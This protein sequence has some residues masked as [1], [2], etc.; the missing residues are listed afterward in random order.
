MDFPNWLTRLCEKIR[1][2]GGRAL[3]VGGAVRDRF[4]GLPSKDFDLEVYG[5]DGLELRRL[6]ESLG[7]VNAV[8]EQFVVYK[9][10]PTEAPEDEADVSLP[11]RESKSG[12]GHRGFVI[13]GDP[14]MS[15]FEATR[16]RDFTIN[17]LMLDP[18]SG[19]VIDPQDGMAD[20][21][22]RRLRVVDPKTFIEDSLRVLRGAQFAARFEFSLAPETVAL[23]RTIPLDDLPSERVWG[24]FEKLLTKAVRP[25]IGFEALETLSA[26]DTCFPEL[27]ELKRKSEPGGAPGGWEAML[28]GIDEGARRIGDLPREKKVTVMLALTARAFSDPSGQSRTESFLDRL[29]VFSL[30]GYDV[31][32]QVIAL[33]AEGGQPEKLIENGKPAPDGAF[34]RLALRVDGDLLYRVA[35]ASAFSE[36][37][38]IRVEKFR[39]RFLE[40]G[41]DL[42]PPKPVLLGRHLLEMGVPPGPGIGNLTRLVFERQLEGEVTTL[43][44]A[45]AVALGIL[46]EPG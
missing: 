36:D 24:E 14:A 17:A 42:G 45:R 20:V 12:R 33:V 41:L 9:F 15:F 16:R 35:S 5:V 26:L 4:L 18:L 44:E 8:G 28:A 6:L 32:K 46:S 21:K 19:E 39:K 34:R 38:K 11:R 13:E 25:S 43:D 37:S 23:C 10:R 30:N 3:L 31:R 2:R 1:I 22:A 29:G 40:L 27:A 7:A